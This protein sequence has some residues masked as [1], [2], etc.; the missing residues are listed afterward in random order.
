M[1]KMTFKI[2]MAA[3]CAALA[4]SACSEE[5]A[6]RH[7]VAPAK[8]G[9]I[10][11]NTGKDQVRPGQPLTASIAL[12]TGG[13]NISEATYTWGS[14]NYPS[15]KE[16]NGTAYFSFTAPEDPGQYSLSFNARYSFLGHDAEGN[17]YKDMSSTLDY[18]ATTLKVYPR[19]TES[20]SQPGTYLGT[21]ADKLSSSS[22]STVERAFTFNDDVLSKITEYE[23]YT[24]TDVSTYARK[25]YVVR[26]YAQR[27]FNM[28]VE[29]EYYGDASASGEPTP[30]A[31]EDWNDE[32]WKNEVGQKLQAGTLRLYCKLQDEHTQLWL[33]AFDTGDGSGIYIVRDYTA[34]TVR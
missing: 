19:L 22:F 2:Y 31:E 21:F 10:S 16:E 7:G 29:T 15:E 32:N 28:E 6:T 13:Q 5:D 26:T 4:F 23:I 14:L 27:R 24:N 1:K 25:F 33:S 18:T 20:T 9:T 12:P 3:C 30:I 11:L 8:I 34:N 17:F